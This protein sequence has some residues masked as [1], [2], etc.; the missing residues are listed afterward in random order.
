MNFWPLLLG[1]LYSAMFFLM[2]LKQ[3]QDV[4]TRF[5]PESHVGFFLDLDFV[6][7]LMVNQ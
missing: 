7:S 5:C 3:I 1:L 2:L 6:P 4:S